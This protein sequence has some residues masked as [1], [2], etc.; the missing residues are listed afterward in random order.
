LYKRFGWKEVDAVRIDM[1]PH[2]GTG[3]ATEQCL[4]REPHVGIA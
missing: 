3:I 1:T 2:G 4:I